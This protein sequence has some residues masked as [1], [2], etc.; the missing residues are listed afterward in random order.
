[1]CGKMK[2]PMHRGMLAAAAFAAIL[3]S[4]PCRAGEAA[5][6]SSF[7]SNGVKIGY[8]VQGKGEPVILIH[9]LYSSEMV[10]WELTGVAGMLAQDHQVIAL[11]VRGHGTSDRPESEDAYGVEMVEDVVR[12][13]DK[14]NIKKAHV[15]GYSMGGL[16]AGKLMTKYPD[17]VS[18]VLLG[19]MGWLKDG[20]LL[21]KTWEGL[22]GKDFLK[23]PSACVHSFGKL[24]VSED[25][26]KAVKV[27]VMMLVGDHDPC[28]A[29]Y[30]APLEKLRPDFPVVTVEGAGHITCIMKPQFKEEIKKWIDKQAK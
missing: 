2:Q 4:L 14:L 22:P 13:M 16:I 20:G 28:K 25:E 11:D 27:P 18:S 6:R 12:L 1:M 21:Q 24:A 29:L 17:R 19:G 15:V 26:M 3:A 30:V 23:T 8:M 7:D 9:G 5:V 10:N